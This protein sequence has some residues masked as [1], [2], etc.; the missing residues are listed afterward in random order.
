MLLIWHVYMRDGDRTFLNV[1]RDYIIYLIPFIQYA[2]SIITVGLT[3]IPV[4]FKRQIL[5]YKCSI[6]QNQDDI[7]S[8]SGLSC[9]TSEL[10]KVGDAYYNHQSCTVYIHVLYLYTVFVIL[11]I[12]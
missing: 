11:W 9:R 5:P 7:I 8:D 1:K 6:L 3:G 4:N 10:L 2:E 12:H